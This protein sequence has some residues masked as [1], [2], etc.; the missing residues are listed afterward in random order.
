MYKNL[1]LENYIQGNFHIESYVKNSTPRYRRI[2]QP[3]PFNIKKVS[4]PT[5]ALLAIDLALS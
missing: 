1:E 3:I 2:N 5:P 4:R